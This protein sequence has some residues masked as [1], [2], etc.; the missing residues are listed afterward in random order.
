VRVSRILYLSGDAGVPVLG[1][2]GA[3]V[4]VRALADAFDSLGHEV[5][6]ASPRVDAGENS[7]PSSIRLVEIP[8]VIP[9][10]APDAAALADA[11]QRQA[12]AVAELA[13]QFDPDLVYERYSLAAFS[14]AQ[15]REQLGVPLVVE[16]NAPLRDEAER[17]RQL[18]HTEVARSAERRL[19]D[20][21]DAVFAVSRGV[22][23]WL[24]AEGTE[25]AK[26][27]IVPN[28][29]PARVFPS[30]PAPAPDGDLVVGFAGGM[31]LWHGVDVLLDAFERV[32]AAGGRMRLVAAG[33]GP[34]DDLLR[35][36]P[37]PPDRFQWLGHLSH[38]AALAE[39]EQWDIGVAPFTHVEGFWFSPLKL[40]E[41]MAAGL[42]PVV[43]AL[44][45]LPRVVAQGGAGVVV[46][47]DDPAALAYALLE[48]DRDR[49]RMHA[50]GQAAQARARAGPSWVENARRAV[51]FARRTAPA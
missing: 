13:V 40:Y 46:A 42:C 35:A 6:V 4:H 50:L 34:C 39:L 9:K 38:D 36:A 48:L 27:A 12:D 25:S 32:L 18:R 17:F 28:A 44:G 37:F 7:L 20:A 41:Y 51:A 22:A 3:S 10:T 21:A 8:A 33:S 2:K 14:G 29:F 1:H 31:K 15:V 19:F 23:E 26:V 11:A 49:G 43:S 16:V 24:V 30:K 45:D 47:P 5:V